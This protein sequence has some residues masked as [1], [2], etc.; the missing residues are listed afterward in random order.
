VHHGT[1]GRPEAGTRTVY[2]QCV[3]P[4]GKLPCASSTSARRIRGVRVS[5]AHHVL[6]PQVVTPRAEDEANDGERGHYGGRNC[7]SSH[8]LLPRCR[9]SLEAVPTRRVVKLSRSFSDNVSSDNVISDNVSSAVGRI[10]SERC[11]GEKFA[12]KT[13]RTHWTPSVNLRLGCKNGLRS[14][15]W[16]RWKKEMGESAEFFC[17]AFY[18]L[19]LTCKSFS[20][21]PLVRRRFALLF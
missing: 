9:E 14:T 5:T 19:V 6:A 11:V 15:V 17:P 18:F 8:T 4:R 13:Q 7:D 16:Q 12:Q 21:P 1:Y 10:R 20:T 2:V 3:P